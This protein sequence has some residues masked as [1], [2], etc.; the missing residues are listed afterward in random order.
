MGLGRMTYSEATASADRLSEIAAALD[1]ELT[2]LRSEIFSMDEVLKSEGANQ[3]LETY[4][5]LDKELTKCP[6]K[7]VE[8]EKYLRDAIEQYKQD[9]QTLI[10]E[11]K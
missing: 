10:E 1:T 8:F 11:G 7:I 3:V 6:T 2:N 9:D 5:N 4:D